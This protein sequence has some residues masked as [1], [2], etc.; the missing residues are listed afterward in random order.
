MYYINFTYQLIG[1]YE[2]N[3]SYTPFPHKVYTPNIYIIAVIGKIEV[4]ILIKQ[5]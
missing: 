5:F 3:G 2:F 1:I 4:G